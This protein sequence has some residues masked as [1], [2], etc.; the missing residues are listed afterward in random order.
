MKSIKGKMEKKYKNMYYESMSNT[1]KFIFDYEK[2]MK[3]SSVSEVEDIYI[4]PIFG[5]TDHLDYYEKVSCGQFFQ[6]ICVPVLAINSKDDPFFHPEMKMPKVEPYNPIY[7]SNPDFGGHCG[8]MFHEDENDGTNHETSF[9]WVSR[10]LGRF[11]DHVDVHQ[12][13]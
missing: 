8:Y 2:L 10:E 6:R 13:L 1:G 3:A 11:I 12:N 7:F 5:F 9:S 4:S